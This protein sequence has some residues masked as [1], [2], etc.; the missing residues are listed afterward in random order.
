MQFQN[1]NSPS[2]LRI[3]KNSEWIEGTTYTGVDD[4]IPHDGGFETNR[5]VQEEERANK[6][7]QP[8][9]IS[10]VNS[11]Q[12]L[13]FSPAAG[14][15]VSSQNQYR[16]PSRRSRRSPKKTNQDNHATNNPIRATGSHPTYRLDR[17]ASVVH[18]RRWSG[19]DREIK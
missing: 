19:D 18:F 4:R 11:P 10:S 15:D 14:L 13:R 12:P 1:S 9:G 8:T 3:I 2:E 17:R 7:P 6:S 5:D 16:F